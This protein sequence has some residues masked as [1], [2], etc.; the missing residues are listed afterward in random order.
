VESVARKRYS[1]EE[2]VAKLREVDF[3]VAMGR[4]FVEALNVV[5][6][7]E[8]AYARWQVEYGGLTRTLR[9]VRDGA[10]AKAKLPGSR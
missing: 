9:P 10:A 2:I 5:G 8:N 3:M 7:P 4:P 1:A 6:V